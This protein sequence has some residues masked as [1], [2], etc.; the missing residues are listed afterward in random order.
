MKSSPLSVVSSQS[1][2]VSPTDHRPRTTDKSKLLLVLAFLLAAAPLRSANF[3][4]TTNGSGSGSFGSPFALQTA[5]SASNTIVAGD[6]LWLMPGSY[7]HS[8]QG[9]APTSD[10]PGWIFKSFLLG[11]AVNPIWIRSFSNGVNR[12]RLDAG[13]YATNFAF[14]ASVRPLIMVGDPNVAASGTYNFFRD[15]EFYSSSTETRQSQQESSF[16]TD[17]FRG[18]GPYFFGVGS[19]AINCFAH[20]MSAGIS[21]WKQNFGGGAYGCVIW[22]NGYLG[23][24]QNHGHGIYAQGAVSAG[25]LTKPIQRNLFSAGFDKNFQVYGSAQAGTEISHFRIAQNGFIGTQGSHGGNVLGTRVGGNAN[26]MQDDQVTD[27]WFY[28]S[29]LEIFYHPD[30]SA[31]ADCITTGNYLVNS[32]FQVSSWQSLVL[33]NNTWFWVEASDG[34]AFNGTSLTTNTT[35][36]PWTYNFNRYYITAL[37]DQSFRIE[38]HGPVNFSGWKAQTGYD[39]ASTITTTFPVTNYVILLANAYDTNRANLIIYNWSGATSIAVDMSALGWGGGAAVTLTQGQDP[40]VDVVGATLSPASLLTVDVRAVSHTVAIPYGY[41]ATLAPKSFPNYGQWVIDKQTAGPT[42]PPVTNTFASVISSFNPSTGVTI[43]NSP[44]D[45]GSLGNGVTP[46]TRTNNLNVVTSLTAPATASGN[47]FAKWQRNGVDYSVTRA[48]T[49][50]NT[51]DVAFT[52]FY[53]TPTFTLSVASSNPSSG[54]VIQVSPADNTGL[55]LGATA[56]TRD[57]NSGQLVNLTAPPSLITGQNFQK[58]NYNAG[59]F[60][61]AQA[62]TITNTAAITMTAVFTNQVTPPLTNGLTY[63][64]RIRAARF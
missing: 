46:Y 50:T 33:T 8:P 43:T 62:I 60:S 15:I 58:W 29:D 20:D 6:T 35:I 21:T 7:S 24:Q 64:G 28:G 2:V 5:L 4:A 42:P 61:T 13:A 38:T 30:P 27:N 49:F 18:D 57:Y 1:S 45:N 44:A 39:A 48:I 31:Y 55:S 63:S 56:F 36:I 22:N 25:G 52:V 11:T 19:R 9:Y 12:A 16:P 23:T 17:I 59:L 41:A 14:K 54:A 26:R 53:T 37:A 3:Y 10:Q 51:A 40:L 47:D 34:S 32:H